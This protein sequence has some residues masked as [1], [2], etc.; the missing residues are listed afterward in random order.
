[1]QLELLRDM[2]YDQ[3][4]TALAAKLQLPDPERLRLTMYN[5]YTSL[6]QK[7]P[8]RFRDGR[9]LE[10]VLVHAQHQNDILFYEVGGWTGWWCRWD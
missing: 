7:A 2:D 4:T 10:Q 9:R 3:V 6:P 1:M 5:T 8:L